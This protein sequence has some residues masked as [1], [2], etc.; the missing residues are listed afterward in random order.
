MPSFAVY[1]PLLSMLPTDLLYLVWPVARVPGRVIV[2]VNR[3]FRC[4]RMQEFLGRTETRTN[5]PNA[6]RI[7]QVNLVD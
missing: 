6:F 2:R 5:S 4:D 7:I 1:C 3:V